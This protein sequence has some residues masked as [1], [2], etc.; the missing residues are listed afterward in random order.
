MIVMFH[1][2][3]LHDKEWYIPQFSVHSPL[4]TNTGENLDYRSFTFFS[5]ILHKR[6]ILNNR[7]TS[8]EYR[9]HL[10]RLYIIYFSYIVCMFLSI[11]HF[12]NLIYPGW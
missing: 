9:L 5:T 12:L 11:S 1:T 8:L 7:V 2:R 4:T 10:A 6:E 3:Q